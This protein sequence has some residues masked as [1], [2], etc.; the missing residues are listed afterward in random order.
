MLECLWVFEVEEFGPMIVAIDSHGNNMTEDVR[1]R[2]S[3]KM[4]EV[5]AALGG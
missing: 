1:R 2:V 5:L 3:A 4:D